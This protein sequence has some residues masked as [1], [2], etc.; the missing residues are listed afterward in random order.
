MPP[1]N[2][3]ETSPQSAILLQVDE[4]ERG[5]EKRRVQEGKLLG[6]GSLNKS[7][8]HGLGNRMQCSSRNP[9]KPWSGCEVVPECGVGPWAHEHHTERKAGKFRDTWLLSHGLHM[10]LLH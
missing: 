6:K 4:R 3:L 5:K 8:R 7:L 1:V 9:Q 10:I 2:H